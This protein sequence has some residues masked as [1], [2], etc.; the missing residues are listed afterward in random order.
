MGEKLL[1]LDSP[2][3]PVGSETHVPRRDISGQGDDV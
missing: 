2:M 1:S 3:N